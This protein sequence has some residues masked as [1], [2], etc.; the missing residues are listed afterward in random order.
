MNH[1]EML[2]EEVIEKVGD[3]VDRQAA[4]KKVEQF[5]KRGNVFLLFEVMKLRGEVERLREDVQHPK[6]N[7]SRLR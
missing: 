4:A 3:R 7:A 6:P 2:L 1:K 5:L